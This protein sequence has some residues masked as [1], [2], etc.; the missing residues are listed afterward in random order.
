MWTSGRANDLESDGASI[1][2]R[3]TEEPRGIQLR[4]IAGK[5]KSRR[6]IPVRE[7]RIRPT[8]DRVREA[9]M[10]ILGPR[11]PGAAV[12]DLFA[13]SGA[14]GLEALSRGASHVTF[15]ERSRGA[16]QVLERN[17]RALGAGGDTTVVHGDALAHLRTLDPLQC[18]LALADPPYGRGYA[19]ELISRFG[20]RPFA[21]EL[22]IE[23]RVDEVL[24]P[25]ISVRQRRYGDTVLTAVA[26]PR[27]TARD[28]TGLPAPEPGCHGAPKEMNPLAAR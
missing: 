16:L 3:P 13:G 20:Q 12:A 14:L 23:H 24:P 28:E 21:G 11:I 15:V 5:W 27:G 8:T 25:D 7:R 17:I 18:D 9:W 19:S 10:S 4:I 22:W 6:L 2:G 1:A 26:L